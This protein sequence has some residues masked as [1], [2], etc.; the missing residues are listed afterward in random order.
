MLTIGMDVVDGLRATPKWLP[1][2]LLWDARGAE[3]FGRICTLDDYYLTRHELALLRECVG[4]IAKAA[5][6]RARVIEPGSGLA[7]KTRIL[8]DALVDPA[9][10]VPIEVEA[11]QLSAT[12]A[13]FRR[14]YP[15]LEIE[16]ICGD[17]TKPIELP[18]PHRACRRSLVFFPGSTIGN[19]ELGDAESFLARFAR[20]AGEGGLLVLGADS[21]GDP[22]RLVR[23]YDDREG[24]TAE[25]D[26]NVLVRLNREYGADFEPAA[27]THRAVWN[28]AQT[29]IEMHLVSTRS[30]R[31]R[32]AGHEI[33]FD[34]GE[35]I[36]TEHCYKYPVP[37]IEAL[38]R[39]AGWRVR[40]TFADPRGWMRTWLCERAG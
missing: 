40:E 32:V 13:E 29:R 26:R 33:A 20:L 39:R 19:F 15:A 21:N 28:A 30:Q 14:H 12:M 8:L 34:A 4:A 2:Q 9:C 3:L 10:Y 25:F 11:E 16:Q 5:G 17:Y 24:V 22:E 7:L 23:A 1:C 35:P 37:A 6:P 38:L 18:A 27:F 36:V 31:V